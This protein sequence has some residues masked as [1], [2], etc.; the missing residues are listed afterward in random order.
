MAKKDD[1]ERERARK[2]ARE[3]RLRGA[4]ASELIESDL[5]AD[6]DGAQRTARR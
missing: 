6:K 5:S 3:T 4:R 1:T 2:D